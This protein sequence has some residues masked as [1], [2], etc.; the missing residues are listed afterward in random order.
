MKNAYKLICILMILLLI[1]GCSLLHK[2]GGS[3]YYSG[4]R[5]DLFRLALNSFP[6]PRQGLGV[7]IDESTIEKDDFGREL[8]VVKM[9][10]ASEY[11]QGDIL[12]GVGTIDAAYVIAQAHDDQRV[13]YYEDICFRLFNSQSQ[14]GIR[15]NLLEELKESN[16]WNQPL[17][18][19]KCA[20]RLYEDDFAGMDNLTFDESAHTSIEDAFGK[21]YSIKAESEEGYISIIKITADASG[22]ELYGVRVKK[23]D[24]NKCFMVI[25]HPGKKIDMESNVLELTTVDFG[26]ELHQLKIRND[27]DFERCP[28][29]K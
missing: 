25:Y 14:K 12:I 6:G 7:K 16:D 10:Q 1:S 13:Y 5:Y 19:E 4:T 29:D 28:G 21:R 9:M 18:L 15:Q 22:K 11:Y 27:W 24:K 3:P 8:Y 17:H 20:S 26:E 2:E 23:L